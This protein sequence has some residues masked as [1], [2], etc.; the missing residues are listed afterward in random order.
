MQ[1]G[2][3]HR[4]RGL[5]RGGRVGR[6]GRGRRHRGRRRGRPHQPG[7]LQTAQLQRA[8][9]YPRRISF[10]GRQTMLTRAAPSLANCQRGWGAGSDEADPHKSGGDADDAR[11]TSKRLKTIAER[12]MRLGTRPHASD[13]ARD[14]RR[15]RQRTVVS[16]LA[17]RMCTP[18]SALCVLRIE[19]VFAC[20]CKM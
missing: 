6:W 7:R 11:Q 16:A 18:F 20:M 4:G 2:A 9:P 1:H 3:G 12:T 10:A 14:C 13:A 17:N 19:C 8:T 5:E 15:R